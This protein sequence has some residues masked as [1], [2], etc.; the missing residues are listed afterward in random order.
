M[1]SVF[2]VLFLRRILSLAVFKNTKFPS[3]ALFYTRVH[4]PYISAAAVTVK[5]AMSDTELTPPVPDPET[6]PDSEAGPTKE[7]TDTE[8]AEGSAGVG[9]GEGGGT[10]EGNKD[11]GS[12]GKA[13]G[14]EGSDGDSHEG[15]KDEKGVQVGEGEVEVKGGGDGGMSHG[16]GAPE[17]GDAGGAKGGGEEMKGGGGGSPHRGKS[18]GG[19]IGGFF[20]RFITREPHLGKCM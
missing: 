8:I 15:G 19:K 3:P 9:G 14:T 13:K 20:S 6:P 7:N 4:R 2:L 11:A 12:D 1:L 18:L 16:G 5:C 17:K 10:Q